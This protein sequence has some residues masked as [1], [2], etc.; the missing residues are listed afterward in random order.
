MF[1]TNKNLVFTT[2]ERKTGST[3]KR[4]DQ[5]QIKYLYWQYHLIHL[6]GTVANLFRFILTYVIIHLFCGG[7]H[8][9]L[10]LIAV[11]IQI[12]KLPHC[13]WIRTITLNP[14][15]KSHYRYEV[16]ISLNFLWPH[17]KLSATCISP[18]NR[19]SQLTSC[20]SSGLTIPWYPLFYPE[21]ILSR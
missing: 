13:T 11:L 18:I 16:R 20:L 14:H 17:W 4:E 10:K 21:L 8:L 9:K 6:S 5:V 3:A 2:M 1:E 12:A 15:C 7:L 19:S